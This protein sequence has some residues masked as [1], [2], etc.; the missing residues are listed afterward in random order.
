MHAAAPEAEYLPA[1]QLVQAVDPEA[2]YWPAGQ[3]VPRDAA[4]MSMSTE[5]FPP[6][7]AIVSMREVT[8]SSVTT[9]RAVAPFPE[10]PRL[11]ATEL[12][13]RGQLLPLR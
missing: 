7:G 11:S 9:S 8:S 6:G 10:C 3:L 5:Y 13:S 4:V 12:P 2:E 1:G